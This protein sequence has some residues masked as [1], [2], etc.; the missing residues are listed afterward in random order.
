MWENLKNMRTLLL[1]LFMP[2]LALAQ[3]SDSLNFF[4]SI[5]IDTPLY[6]TFSQ[7]GC[8]LSNKVLDSE[9]YRDSL[10]IFQVND[11]YKCGDK[12][13]F[14]G[15]HTGG[16]YF[17]E[18]DA[19]T[20]LLY[21][22]TEKIELNQFIDNVNIAKEKT[23][24]REYSKQKSIVNLK[25]L[26][27]KEFE[28][29]DSYK[30]YGVAIMRAVPTDNYSM[31][32]AEFKI[33]NVSKKTIKYITFNFYGLNPVKDKVLYKAGAYNASRKGIGP[34]EQYDTG[35]W[36][37]DNVWL[38]DVVNTLKLFSVNIIY[39]DGTSKAVKITDDVWLD[40][41]IIDNINLLNSLLDKAEGK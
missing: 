15:Y 12:I 3:K 18:Y 25:Y 10:N 34:V 20:F 21:K 29:L 39:M 30:K 17:S 38:T 9:A 22:D 6:K 13:V 37:F 5:D 27:L 7:D 23:D 28:K 8:K 24:L 2:F 4:A 33:M 1:L 16:E 35:S 31:T 11:V 26:F 19:E 40:D 14:K 41:D 36:E 32:G